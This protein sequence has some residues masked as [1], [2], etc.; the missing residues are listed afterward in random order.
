[1]GALTGEGE[2]CLAG[3]LGA[4]AW[5]RKAVN[6]PSAGGNVSKGTA[7]TAVVVTGAGGGGG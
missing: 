5:L 6:K 3:A 1:M 4:L 2:G 7:S